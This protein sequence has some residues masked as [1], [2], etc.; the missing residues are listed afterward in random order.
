[1]PIKCYFEC[2][3]TE[4]NTCCYKCWNYNDCLR[5]QTK[6]CVTPCYQYIHDIHSD[7]NKE[8]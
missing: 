7:Q 2:S 6:R 3:I 4:E 8:D 1:M 5:K